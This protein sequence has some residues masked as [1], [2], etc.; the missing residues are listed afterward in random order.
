ML[1]QSKCYVWRD[2]EQTLGLIKDQLQCRRCDPV[3][4]NVTWPRITLQKQIDF[5]TILPRLICPGQDRNRNQCVIF[6][7]TK[8]T[9][10]LVMILPEAYI[11]CLGMIVTK[12]S[13]SFVTLQ[14]LHQFLLLQMPRA[15]CQGKIVTRSGPSEIHVNLAT[16][17][18]HILPC[19]RKAH[20]YY[21]LVNPEPEVQVFFSVPAKSEPK[22]HQ[23]LWTEF[24]A[25]PFSKN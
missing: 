15:L 13:I 23:I 25:I 18:V 19:P 6:N 12:P 3:G 8:Y 7:V 4:D 22:F 20:V 11:L 5:V 24:T 21:L 17:E 10:I 16:R 9:C 1:S 2:K 14:I